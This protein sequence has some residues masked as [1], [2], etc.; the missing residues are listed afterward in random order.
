MEA[1]ENFCCNGDML[2]MEHWT[3]AQLKHG[4]SKL[5]LDSPDNPKRTNLTWRWIAQHKLDCPEEELETFRGLAELP[6]IDKILP[7]DEA[8]QRWAITRG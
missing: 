4:I 6:I 2:A 5:P 7:A 1:P 3:Q 8:E